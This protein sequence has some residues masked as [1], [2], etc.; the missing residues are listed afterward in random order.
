M[1]QQAVEACVATGAQE[2]VRKFRAVVAAV[3]ELENHFFQM[4]RERL[5]AQRHWSH[6][7]PAARNINFQHLSSKLLSRMRCCVQQLLAAPHSRFPHRIFLLLEG[8]SLGDICLEEKDCMLDDFSQGLIAGYEDK[9][10]GDP[11]ALAVL[12][13][14]A[15]AWRLDFADVESRHASLR[16]SLK[17]SP[18]AKRPLQAVVSAFFAGRSLAK[19]QHRA[20]GLGAKQSFTKRKTKAGVGRTR[21]ALSTLR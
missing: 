19:R 3:G 8:P 12:R 18:Q 5:L 15:L 9:G 10:L 21:R 16:R 2:G 4:V 17:L 1:R 13:A 14:L 11:E 20:G 6:M 7:P